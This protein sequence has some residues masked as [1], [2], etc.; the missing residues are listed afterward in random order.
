MNKYW[1]P[2]EIRDGRLNETLRMYLEYLYADKIMKI[3]ETNNWNQSYPHL[4]FAGIRDW[5]HF[6]PAGVWQQEHNQLIDTWQTQLCTD[7]LLH[8]TG[9][10]R[11][12]EFDVHHV[13]Q[14]MILNQAVEGYDHIA[15]LA[16]DRIQAAEKVGIPQNP[17]RPIDQRRLPVKPRYFWGFGSNALGAI[18]RAVLLAIWQQQ[19]TRFMYR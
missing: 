10:N 1:H 11:S 14:Y 17:L 16:H 9:F 13:K 7:I 8:V 18:V 3:I 6:N 12:Y 5:K 19:D 2:S 4:G 15:Y